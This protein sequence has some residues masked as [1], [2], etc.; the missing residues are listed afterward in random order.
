MNTGAKHDNRYAAA[1][2]KA[3]EGTLEPNIKNGIPIRAERR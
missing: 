1:L 3:M 2:G